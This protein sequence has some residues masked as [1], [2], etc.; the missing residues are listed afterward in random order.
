MYDPKG[1][2]RER[3]ITSVAFEEAEPPAHL[4]DIV[5]RYL[6][7]RTDQPL[8]QDYQFH[9]LPDACTY[10]IFDQ[11]DVRVTGVTQL[12]ASFEELNLGRTFHFVNIRFLPG[13]WQRDLA[14][15]EHGLVNRPYTGP[16]A[17][18]DVNRSLIGTGFS[19]QQRILSALVEDLHE[20]G[21]VEPNPVTKRIFERMDDI[22][23]VADMADVAGLSARQ[24]QRV[25]K[26]TTG[27]APHDFLKVLRLQQSLAGEP[28]L[29]YADQS[30]FIH[31]FK[32]ATGYTPGTFARKFDV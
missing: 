16:L 9:A 13:V 27:L 14:A 20:D 22:H 17:L 18:V 21:L 25:L 26:R 32:K 4:A 8:V 12:R 30:H 24:L 28:S 15:V 5:H 1:N 31:A 6:D 3:T 2:S 19:D 7:L 29:S 23:S 10:L 11:L